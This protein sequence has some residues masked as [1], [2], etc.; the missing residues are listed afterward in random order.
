MNFAQDVF[1]E[2]NVSSIR[3]S[4]F[5]SAD[6]IEQGKY[7]TWYLILTLSNKRLCISYTL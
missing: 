2:T 5:L 4:P 6:T 3:N 1:I 7:K